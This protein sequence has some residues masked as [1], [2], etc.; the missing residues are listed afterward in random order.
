MTINRWLFHMA[1]PYFHDYPSMIFPA[2][3]KP[4]RSEKEAPGGSSPKSAGTAPWFFK[5]GW[6]KSPGKS[7]RN[8]ASTLLPDFYIFW[9]MILEATRDHWDDF[10]WWFY[11]RC[12]IAIPIG[13]TWKRYEPESWKCTGTVSGHWVC[14]GS[15]FLPGSPNPEIAKNGRRVKQQL[16]LKEFGPWCGFCGEISKYL[17]TMIT[18]P[19]KFG[20]LNPTFHVLF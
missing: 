18:W 7:S 9:R 3:Q 17:L 1:S 11:C 6:L 10:R 5:Q 13:L 19:K 15:I 2:T 14:H 16:Q 4:P 12:W 8:V 20:T